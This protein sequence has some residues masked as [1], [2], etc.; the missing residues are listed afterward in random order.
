VRLDA[1]YF[2]PHHVE[3]SEAAF[4][5]PCAHRKPAPG[6][7]LT[8]AAELDLDL[9]A[10]WMVGDR[11]SDVR[12]GRSA[13]CR[14]ILLGDGTSTADFVARDLGHAAELILAHARNQDS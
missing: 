9:A 1:L 6:M 14:T 10:S 2:C 13:G 4:A 3:G 8:A 5:R 11:E 12:A 7:L